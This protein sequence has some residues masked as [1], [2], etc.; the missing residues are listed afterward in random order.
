MVKHKMLYP[1]CYCGYTLDQAAALEREIKC[2]LESLPP[3]LRFTVTDNESKEDTSQ[4]PDA[5]VPQ[6]QMQRCTL[7]IMA[8]RLTIMVYLPFLRQHLTSP[9]SS[10]S[11]Q[12]DDRDTSSGSTCNPVL[13]PIY[14]AAQSI[15]Q[16]SLQLG[17]CNGNQPHPRHVPPL[18]LALYP[19]EKAL[20]DAV[21]ICTYIRTF[22]GP[23]F[24]GHTA[25]DSAIAGMRMLWDSTLGTDCTAVFERLKKRFRV[26]LD[27]P[28]AYGV[29]RKH[30]QIAIRAAGCHDTE[31]PKYGGEAPTNHLQKQLLAT[32][33][34]RNASNNSAGGKRDGNTLS[35]VRDPETGQKDK[36]HAKKSH[37]H[38]SVG[39]RVRGK[40]TPF[41]RRPKIGSSSST[42][43]SNIGADDRASHSQQG[44]ELQ[45]TLDLMSTM[46]EGQPPQLSSHVPNTPAALPTHEPVH[47]SRSCSLDQDLRRQSHLQHD[48][49]PIP[50][51]ITQFEDRDDHLHTNHV[52]HVETYNHG[53]QQQDGH[54]NSVTLPRSFEGGKE[55]E[56]QKASGPAY[57]PGVS[58]VTVA[59]SPYSSS[60]H[61]TPAGG[62][63]Y[64]ASGKATSLDQAIVSHPPAPPPYAHTYYHMDSGNGFNAITYNQIQGQENISYTGVR[65]D[66]AGEPSPSIIHG[67]ATGGM[68]M[69][70]TV[71]SPPVYEKARSTMFDVK[72]PMDMLVQQEM[73]HRYML[74]HQTTYGAD[75]HRQDP[76]SITEPA[77]TPQPAIPIDASQRF[78]DPPVEH[79]KYFHS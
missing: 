66:T 19:V 45:S 20:L 52:A 26:T 76:I 28:S 6:L 37:A 34:R 54:V 27:S 75:Q 57:L 29:K 70:A 64:T 72:P 44:L 47:R 31:S 46:T 41:F 23:L 71:P 67:D 2:F 12:P 21:I 5:D 63:P 15:I 42:S 74:Q 55:H 62:S 22:H 59:S 73:H 32:Q 17:L 10:M 49:P 50:P 16:A 1:D 33:E 7:I 69:A 68:G 11:V 18:L 43:A 78:W 35:N 13:H 53:Y 39:V 79:F 40:E 14:H 8:Q 9:F 30:E 4:F 25:A 36:K 56:Q 58:P 48:S 65:L 60:G 38:P 24:P 51:F 61:V 77:W 3:S